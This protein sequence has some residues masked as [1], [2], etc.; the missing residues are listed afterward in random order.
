MSS[1]WAGQCGAATLAAFAGRMPGLRE[2][3]PQREVVQTKPECIRKQKGNK[4][5]IPD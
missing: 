4:N 2:G 5:V 1:D 3:E